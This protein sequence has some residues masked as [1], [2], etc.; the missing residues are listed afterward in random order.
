MSLYFKFNY[1]LVIKTRILKLLKSQV[2]FYLLNIQ[3]VYIFFVLIGA[4]SKAKV[5][6]YLLLYKK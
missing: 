4:Q 1:N 6:F 3:F 5:F 2:K